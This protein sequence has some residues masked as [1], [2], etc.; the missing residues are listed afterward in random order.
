MEGDIVA[1][2]VSGKNYDTLLFIG[3]EGVIPVTD[4]G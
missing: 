4:G 2:H 1:F 3:N